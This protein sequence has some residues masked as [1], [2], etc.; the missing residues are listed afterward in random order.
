[1]GITEVVTAPR[2]LWQN[3]YVERVIGSIRRDAWNRLSS[4]THA[5]CATFFHLTW[6][7]TTEPERICHSTRIVRTRVPSSRL[8]AAASSPYRKSAG[9]TI[10]TSASPPD[11][12]Y[13]RLPWVARW[14]VPHCLR[15]LRLMAFDIWNT[16]QPPLPS[17]QR[18]SVCHGWSL[19][20]SAPTPIF[21]GGE[22]SAGTGR[23]K[24]LFLQRRV[25]AGDAAYILRFHNRVAARAEPLNIRAQRARP[26]WVREPCGSFG[27][28]SCVAAP[29]TF[30][31]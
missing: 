11:G 2:S 13:Y 1:M 7:I 5:I 22:F 21:V 30:L 18:A 31:K 24:G 26:N 9:C 29:T 10:A 15:I 19:L 17:L 23:R 16:R 20:A 12:T 28:K 8:G 6:T 25:V 27:I 3:A 4:L 14:P